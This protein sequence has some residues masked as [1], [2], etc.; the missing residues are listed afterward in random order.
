MA[1][2]NLFF[3]SILQPPFHLGAAAVRYKQ[4]FRWEYAAKKAHAGTR[5]F[6]ADRELRD[7]LLAFIQLL[8]YPEVMLQS[9]SELSWCSPCRSH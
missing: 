4:I 2:Q 7:L 8:S 9:G 3:V 6:F 1:W 5:A